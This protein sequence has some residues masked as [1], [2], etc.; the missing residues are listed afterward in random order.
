MSFPGLYY[1]GQVFRQS[2]S[3]A[4]KFSK[5]YPT[6]F[7]PITCPVSLAEYFFRPEKEDMARVFAIFAR[8]SLGEGGHGTNFVEHYECRG[9]RLLS[10]QK[11]ISVAEDW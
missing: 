8:R 9:T 1:D 5:R 6:Q 4:I 11:A 10:D 7:R 2:D 3:P